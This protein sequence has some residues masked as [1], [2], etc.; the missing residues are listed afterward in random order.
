[1]CLRITVLQVLTVV[2]LYF[3]KAALNSR[4][5]IRFTTGSLQPNSDRYSGLQ[6]TLL[7]FLL[8][9]AYTVRQEYRLLHAAIIAFVYHSLRRQK[10]VGRPHILPLSFTLHPDWQTLVSQTADSILEVLAQIE[11]VQF[12]DTFFPSLVLAYILGAKSAKYGS[13]FNPSRL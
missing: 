13:I 9:A 6:Y 5:W 7:N 4:Q 1:M 2:D 11:L 3:Y 10:I 8:L 12:S